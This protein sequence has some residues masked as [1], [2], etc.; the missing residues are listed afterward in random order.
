[1]LISTCPEFQVLPSP[2]PCYLGLGGIQVP[3]V[4]PGKAQTLFRLSG[5]GLAACP[6]RGEFNHMV[7]CAPMGLPST[8]MYE[9]SRS[10][11]LVGKAYDVKWY[12][13]STG[14]SQRP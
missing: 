5:K 14:F 10:G 8:G 7:T 2:L 11:S 9:V 12:E 3:P 4:L 1:M 13:F 6:L